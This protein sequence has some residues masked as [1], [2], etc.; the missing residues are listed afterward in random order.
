M[1][2]VPES[3]TSLPSRSM[4]LTRANGCLEL[5]LTGDLDDLGIEDVPDLAIDVVAER[6]DVHAD[7]RRGDAC[8]AGQAHT[9]EEVGH[10]R[11]HAIVDLFDGG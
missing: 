5:E 6:P 11:T 7:L 10:E 3:S 9:V 4:P 1:S 2:P 8:P